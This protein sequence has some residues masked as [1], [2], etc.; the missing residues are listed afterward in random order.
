[1]KAL[2]PLLSKKKK[3]K[4]MAI[5]R[6][7]SAAAFV[8]PPEQQQ[9]Q[10]SLLSIMF[11]CSQRV[12]VIFFL[13][14]LSLSHHDHHH[15]PPDTGHVSPLHGQQE[16]L[17]LERQAAHLAKGFVR[18]LAHAVDVAALGEGEEEEVHSCHDQDQPSCRVCHEANKPQKLKSMPITFIADDSSTSCVSVSSRCR[19]ARPG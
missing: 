2:L 6:E 3:K 8:C 18:A 1:M 14:S 5:L 17:L 19:R 10:L 4:E 12:N 15:L 9:Q 7:K 16:L 13:S 11:S